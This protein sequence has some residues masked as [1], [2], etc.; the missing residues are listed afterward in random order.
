[1]FKFKIYRNHEKQQY[2]EDGLYCVPV[3]DDWFKFDLVINTDYTEVMSFE[4]YVLF[5]KDENPTP[6]TKVLLSD[7]SVVFAV[8]KLS[9]FEA[10]YTEFKKS[11]I[12][13]D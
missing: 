9:T 7:G 2:G 4:E 12:S 8:N 1:M 6:C 10:N 11:K 13:T 5:D 3:S